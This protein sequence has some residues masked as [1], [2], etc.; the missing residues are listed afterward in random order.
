MLQLGRVFDRAG[1]F[2][3]IHSHADYY[4]LPFTRYVRTPTVV[5]LHGRL[6]L[7]DIEPLFREYSDVN[8]V[9]ISDAQREPLPFV[10][11]VATVYNGLDLADYTFGTGQGGYLAFLGRISPEKGLDIAI[12]VAQQVGMP[13]KIAAKVDTVDQGYYCT[14][15]APLLVDDSVQ[16]IGEVDQAGKNEFLGKACALLSASVGRPLAS[17]EAAEPQHDCLRRQDETPSGVPQ[18]YAIVARPDD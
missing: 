15:I 1:E 12:R 17:P 3:L 4:T 5:T 2:D 9:S 6:D 8:L 10:T 13:L 18:T 7:P 16:F 11:W 14:K